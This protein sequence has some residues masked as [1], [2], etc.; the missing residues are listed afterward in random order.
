MS[1]GDD[2]YQKVPEVLYIQNNTGD[3]FYVKYG[4]AESIPNAYSKNIQLIDATG[5]DGYYQFEYSTITDLWMSERQFN[6]LVSQISIYR[7]QP[8]DTTYVN[9]KYYNKKSAWKHK[10]YSDNHYFTGKQVISSYNQLTVC[11]SMFAK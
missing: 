9:P 7:I 3:D 8:N 4:F 2:Y 1:C 6:E 5:R 11:D 10:T